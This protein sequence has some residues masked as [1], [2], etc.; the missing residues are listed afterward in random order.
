MGRR[1]TPESKAAGYLFAVFA[2]IVL[3][4]LWSITTSLPRKIEHLSVSKGHV[5]PNRVVRRVEDP[6][7]RKVVK[8]DVTHEFQNT[9]GGAEP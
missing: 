7:T 3:V 2:C 1:Q 6:L 5:L 8:E 4:A 9:A